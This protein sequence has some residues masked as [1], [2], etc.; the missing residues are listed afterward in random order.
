MQIVN[1]AR[2]VMEP[3]SAV[4]VVPIAAAALLV[5][6]GCTHSTTAMSTSATAE[7]QMPA[8][9]PNPDPRVGLKA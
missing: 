3:R 6:A 9:A 4:R 1:V 7:S 2:R 5:A 8:G